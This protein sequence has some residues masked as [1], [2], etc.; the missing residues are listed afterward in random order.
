L[1]TDGSFDGSGSGSGPDLEIGGMGRFRGSPRWR[2][3]GGGG[4][5]LTDRPPVR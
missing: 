3:W 4:R 2:R 1:D 5:R